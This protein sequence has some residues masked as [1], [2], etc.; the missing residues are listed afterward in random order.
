MRAMESVFH[1]KACD[2]L[3]QLQDSG[4]HIPHFGHS[5]DGRAEMYVAKYPEKKSGLRYRISLFLERQTM[6]TADVAVT[7]QRIPWRDCH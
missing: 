1:L 3:E 6:K 4:G 7:N 5:D 2:F